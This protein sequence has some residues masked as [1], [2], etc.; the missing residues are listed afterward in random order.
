VISEVE[1]RAVVSRGWGEWKGKRDEERTA[2]GHRQKK[3]D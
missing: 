3:M 2:N 1:S